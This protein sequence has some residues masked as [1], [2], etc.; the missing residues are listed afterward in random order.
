[1][2]EAQFKSINLLICREEKERI[3]LLVHIMSKSAKTETGCTEIVFSTQIYR[4]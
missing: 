3:G 4:V 2:N 1:M